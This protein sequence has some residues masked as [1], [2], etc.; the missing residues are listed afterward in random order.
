MKVA[1]IRPES[2]IDYD[3]KIS[4]VV[5]TP[6]CNFKC[7]TCYSKPIVE[8][9]GRYGEKQ[10][11]SCVGD[12]TDAI[13]ICGGEPTLQLGL[14]DF[15]RTVKDK[16]LLVKLDTNG[17]NPGVLEDLKREGLVDYV[18]MDIKGPFSLYAQLVG[19][20]F[21]DERDEVEKGIALVSQFPDYEFRTTVV[22]VAD[23]D[24]FRWFTLEEVDD[25]AKWVYGHGREGKWYVQG[26]KIPETG[27]L[28]LHYE[29]ASETPREKL[30]EVRDG[31]RK[32]FPRCEVRGG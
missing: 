12:W 2:L 11:F 27:L 17:S 3:G 21:I 16:G 22:P 6:G 20:D 31:I 29:E 19:K 26:F 15:C 13:V 30:E 4:T 25:M 9:E 23:G 5:F 8:G 1:E 28:D 32:Y 10:I 14:A 18:A 7:G 24:G